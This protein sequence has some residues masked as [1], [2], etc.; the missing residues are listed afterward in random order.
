MDNL[1][2]LLHLQEAPPAVEVVEV[3]LKQD[4]LITHLLM[5][6]VDMVF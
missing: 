4:M 6:M 1:V 3:L 5:V 2:E